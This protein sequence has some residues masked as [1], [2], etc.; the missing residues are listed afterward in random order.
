MLLF[1]MIIH[2]L[3]LLISCII[4]LSSGILIKIVYE[5]TH[6]KRSPTYNTNETG[7]LQTSTTLVSEIRRSIRTSKT[8]T[9]ISAT[10]KSNNKSEDLNSKPIF[11]IFDGT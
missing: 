7:E 1:V 5:F 8:D 3:G 10:E 9:N 4:T 2:F 6:S 11:S